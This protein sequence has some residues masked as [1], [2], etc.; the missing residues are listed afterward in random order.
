MPQ[1]VICKNGKSFTYLNPAEKASKYSLE[2]ST[3]FKIGFKDSNI[4]VSGTKKYIYDKN[5]NLVDIKFSDNYQYYPLSDK[6]KKYREDYINMFNSYR[7]G[8]IKKSNSP[9]AKAFY[10]ELDVFNK[11]YNREA[12]KPHKNN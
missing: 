3:G 2:L 9:G 5:N 11:F 1:K 6:Q 10:K 7:K 8:T 4:K 12:I